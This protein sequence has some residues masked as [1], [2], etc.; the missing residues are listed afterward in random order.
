M[1]KF[2]TAACGGALALFL[3]VTVAQAQP[4]LLLNADLDATSVSSQ[5]L[6]TPDNWTIIANRAIAGPFNDGASSETW[7]NVAGAGGK[8]LFFKT[9]TG[10]PTAGDVTVI[11]TQ[12][13]PGTAG[14]MYFFRGW[15]GAEANYVG[16]TDPTV[17]SLFVMEFL[18]A[19]SSPIGGATLDLAAAGLGTVPNP[20]FN[21]GLKYGYYG[22]SAVAPAG[23]AFVRVSAQ[24]VDCYANPAGGAQAFTVDAFSLKVPE[25]GSLSLLG[26]G[27][28]VLA[29]RR[30]TK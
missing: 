26:I 13:V 29:A 28:L 8:G 30:R 19:G 22:V 1:R 9:F 15:A 25:P 12:T 27:G 16:L 24:M 11:M 17:D 6:A 10:N 18:D 5:I 3:C 7:N 21:P 23:T 20:N 2:S 4:E 14:Q